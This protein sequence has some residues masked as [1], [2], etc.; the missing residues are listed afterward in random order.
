MLTSAD[1]R[2]TDPV[3]PALEYDT[4]RLVTERV[5]PY[6]FRGRPLRFWCLVFVISMG[7]TLA[8]ARKQPVTGRYLSL[9]GIL[10]FAALLAIPVGLRWSS[11]I[12]LT[13]ARSVDDFIRVSDRRA[14]THWYNTQMRFFEGSRAMLGAGTL[15]GVV[16]EAAYFFGG[17][18]EKFTLSAGLWA[19][20]V[21]FVSAF[22]A[23]CSL[24][25]MYC[26]SVAVYNLGKTWGR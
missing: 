13:W 22:F 6:P 23:G 24:W 5:L 21:V 14:L 1:T 16:A 8:F 7:I 4:I 26:A 15:L 2:S 18:F 25:A 17:Y 12:F 19:G 11:S 9:C 20:T 10:E 3:A